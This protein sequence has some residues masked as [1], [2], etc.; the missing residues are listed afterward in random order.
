LVPRI[1]G[2]TESDGVRENGDG[3]AKFF[4]PYLREK[5]LQQD[6]ETV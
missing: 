4:V 1:K 2:K 5:K 3:G 6:E